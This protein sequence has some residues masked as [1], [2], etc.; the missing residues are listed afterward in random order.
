M[1]KIINI[2]SCTNNPNGTE[3]NLKSSKPFTIIIVSEMF[4]VLNGIHNRLTIINVEKIDKYLL[5]LKLTY[6]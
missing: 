6:R 1:T 4:A 3:I 2:F 5:Q